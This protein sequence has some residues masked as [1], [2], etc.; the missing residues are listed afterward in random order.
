MCWEGALIPATSPGV[1]QRR[2][3][4]LVEQGH[5]QLMGKFGVEGGKAVSGATIG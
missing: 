3:R 2:V 5:G 1:W 4:E